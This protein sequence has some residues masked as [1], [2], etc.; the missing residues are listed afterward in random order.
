MDIKNDELRFEEA[1]AKLDT[2]VSRLEKGELNLEESL[3]LFEEGQFLAKHCAE[4]LEKAELKVEALT[5]DGEIIEVPT[6]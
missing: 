3:A 4:L 5:A 6:G 1:L 2:I